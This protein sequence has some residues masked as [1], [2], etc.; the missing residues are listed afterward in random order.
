MALFIKLLRNNYKVDE[1]KLRVR[2]HLHDYHDENLV[3]KFWSGLLSIPETQFGKIYRKQRSKEKTFRKN[4]GGICFLRYNSV[5]LK[6]EIITY[7]YTLGE[8]VTGK[9]HVP[10]AQRI[11]YSPAKAVM[12]VRFWPGTPKVESGQDGN[13]L[14]SKTS[15]RKG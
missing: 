15:A 9:V 5:H 7:A 10:V 13:A 6:D 3:R 1:S 2:L 4:F 8:R 12:P 14:V 11:E